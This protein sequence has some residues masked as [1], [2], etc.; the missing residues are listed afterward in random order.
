MIS[1]SAE[2]HEAS[3]AT[4]RNLAVR[5]TVQWDGETW[6][7]ETDIDGENY[8]KSFSLNQSA[9]QPGNDLSPLG[10]VDVLTV[11]LDNSTRR[12]DR[13]HTGGD[14]SIRAYFVDGMTKTKVR[15]YVGFWLD[16]VRVEYVRVFTGYIYKEDRRGDSD[17][18]LHIRDVGFALLQKRLSTTLA[19]EATGDEWIGYLAE[20]A[21]VSVDD[22]NLDATPHIIPYAW[23]DDDAALEEMQRCASS[24]SGRLFYDSQGILIFESLSSWARQTTPVMTFSDG[25]L[26]RLPP[27]TNPDDLADIVIVEY[28]PRVGGEIGILHTLDETPTIRP[29]ATETITMRLSN[30]AIAIYKPEPEEDYWLLA[31]GGM[32]MHDYCT[33]TLVTYA[34]RAEV[35]ITNEHPSLSVDVVKLQLRGQPLQGGPT[36]QIELRTNTN[37]DEDDDTRVRSYRGNEYLQT[38]TMAK[39]LAYLLKDRHRWDI[40]VWTLQGAPGI[41]HLEIGDLV[42]FYSGRDLPTARD[43]YVIGINSRWT[44]PSRKRVGGDPIYLQDIQVMDAEKLFPRRDYYIIG[45]TALGAGGAWY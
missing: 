25:D 33:V 38:E 15:L 34:Q 12:Y 26:M 41:P 44:S 5:F 18:V 36:K 4:N 32:V 24:V 30:P 40:P 37:Q 10:S 9:T 20:T 19:L 11:T 7:D 3:I 45:E 13:W 31:P 6:F 17:I 8:F 28:S 35:T 16:E 23:S 21:G 29:G 27:R 43:G 42:R 1:V 2:F 14:G 39:S 22:M